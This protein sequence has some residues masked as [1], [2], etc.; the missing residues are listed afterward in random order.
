M[1]GWFGACSVVAGGLPFLPVPA[2]VP[3][4]V[5]GLARADVALL[6]LGIVVST[7]SDGFWKLNKIRS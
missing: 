7:C 4:S 5:L 6:A 2:P 3:V 1:A